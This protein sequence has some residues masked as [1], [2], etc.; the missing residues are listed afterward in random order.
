MSE[1]TKKYLGEVAVEA[2]V[3]NVKTEDAKTLQS[4]KEYADSLAVNYDAAGAAATAKQEAIADANGKFA[5]VNETLETKADKTALEAEVTRATGKENELSTAIGTVEGKA[6]A[7]TEAIDAINNAD[8]GILAQA[9]AFATAEDEKVQANIDTLAG[10]VG[11]VPADQTVMGIIAN[12]QENAYDDTELRGLITGLDTNKADK[13]QVATDIENAVKA[14]TEARESAVA[15]VQGE[16][17][18]LETTVANNKTAIEGTV[19]TLEEKVNA[20]ETDI[21]GKMTALTERVAANETAVGTTLP[22]AINTEKERAEAKEGE[23]AVAIAAIKEDVDAFFADADMTE[24]AKDTLKE[25]QEYIASDESGASA[26]AASIKQNSDDIDALEGRMGTAEGAI[27]AVEDRTDTVEAKLATVAEGA[28]VNV[29]E[30]VKVNGEALT[31]TDKAVDVIVPTGALAN[32]DTVAEADLETTL[33]TKINAKAEAQDLIDAVATL[34]E[35]DAD[36]DE[37]LQA[38]ETQLGD[39]EGSV[40]DQIAD[41][42]QAAI[43]EAAA[44]ATTKANQALA[45]AKAYADEEDAKIEERVDALETAS[46]THALASDVT[47]LTGRVATVEEK[48]TTLEGE[49]DAVEGAV[50]TKAEQADLTALTTRVATAEGEIDTLQSEMDTVEKKASDNADAIADLE[51]TH[52]EDKATLQA[53]IDANTSAINSFVAISADEINAMFA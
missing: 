44:A 49:M 51:T 37:R 42:K 53:A 15:A 40:A 45:D 3:T 30:T 19:A 9:K 20:N 21:E 33:A 28:Q 11:E 24:S 36:L 7:N 1:L 34:E 17:D 4:A 10:K 12:I 6:D 35:A 5:T 48:V 26:M 27:D 47:A 38:V 50:A 25:L 32:K 46:T 22:N 16:V 39:G 43:D 29:I 8:T 23:L 41:A 14:E 31:V 13:T 18:A 52:N 2:L